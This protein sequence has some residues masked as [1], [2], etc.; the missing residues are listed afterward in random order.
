M[1]RNYPLA[2][3]VVYSMCL[4]AASAASL[5][6]GGITG[7]QV[8]QVLDDTLSWSQAVSAEPQ[9]PA[10]PGDSVVRSANQLLADKIIKLSFD[11]AHATAEWLD[12]LEAE[13]ANS[14]QQAIEAQRIRLE[15]MQKAIQAQISREQQRHGRSRV[16]VSEQS[17]RLPEMEDELAMIRARQN[18]LDTMGLF[19]VEIS[20]SG[21]SAKALKGRIEAMAVSVPSLSNV[22]SASATT[23]TTSLGAGTDVT[24]DHVGI[25]DLI[26]DALRLAR[27]A[28]DIRARDARTV[29]L[30]QVFLVVSRPLVGRTKELTDRADALTNQSTQAGTQSGIRAEFDA[31]AWQFKQ[32]AEALTPLN[33]ARVLLQQCSHNLSNW[34]EA[35]RHQ[36]Y[37][38]LAALGVRLGILLVMLAAL[39]G[40]SNLWRRFLFRYVS[41]ARR[42]NQMMWVRRLTIWGLA[43]AIVCLTPATALSSFATFAGLVIAGVAVAMQSVLLSI[44]GYFHLTGRQGIRVGERVQIGTQIGKVLYLGLVRTHLL[45]LQSEEPWQPTGRVVTYANS[46]VFQASGGVIKWSD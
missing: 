8:I 23:T 45:E 11:F 20:G 7:L 24:A 26:A 46:V 40:C 25:W 35:V 38:A 12:S 15:E 14:S 18:L 5:G 31:L 6:A 9:A 27:K 16:A 3:L 36:Y 44:V 19:G 43:F 34:H 33:D 37:G 21:G 22:P 30:E 28:E 29:A 4:E 1:R 42:R 10:Q 32:T 41:D 13:D 17:A 39:F 2:L